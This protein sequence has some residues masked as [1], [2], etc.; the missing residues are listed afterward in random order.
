MDLGLFLMI[1]SIL[2]ILVGGAASG[3]G[4]S[5]LAWMFISF[6]ITPVLGGFFVAFMRRNE[7]NIRIA[8]AIEGI[9]S[10]ESH[11]LT[12]YEKLTDAEK[13]QPDDT[14]QTKKNN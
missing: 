6:I 2:C 3:K 11:L 13:K 4:R 9:S 7:K 12:D 14:N 8:S 5:A 1:Y 10:D